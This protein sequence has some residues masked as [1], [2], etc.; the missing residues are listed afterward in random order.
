MH[1]WPKWNIFSALM[2]QWP[3]L[4]LSFVT[5]VERKEVGCE[6]WNMFDV[7]WRGSWRRYEAC[8]GWTSDDAVTRQ[9]EEVDKGTA[10][11][12]NKCWVTVLCQYVSVPRYYYYYLYRDFD[13]V[14]SILWLVEQSA[15][16]SCAATACL[17]CCSFSQISQTSCTLQVVIL[18]CS[19]ILFAHMSR[20]EMTGRCSDANCKDWNICRLWKC[21]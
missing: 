20:K 18:N 9:D 17:F 11:R 2:R 13:T 12:D 6:M 4:S 19:F 3:L 7:Q 10:D 21:W 14:V 8:R 1:V 16:V 15:V 5:R